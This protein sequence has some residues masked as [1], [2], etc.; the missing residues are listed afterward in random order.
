MFEKG[1]AALTVDVVTSEDGVK[2]E[3]LSIST[4]LYRHLRGAIIRGDLN[5]GQAL[6]ESEI[7]RQYALAKDRRRSAALLPARPAQFMDWCIGVGLLRMSGSNPQFRHRELQEHGINR[8]R[9]PLLM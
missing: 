3:S 4:Q 1:T 6:S 8:C 2:I 5:P 7:A 9:L